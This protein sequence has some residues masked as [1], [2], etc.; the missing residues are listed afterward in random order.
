MK[1]NA[2]SK[3]RNGLI[4]AI[5]AQVLWGCFPLYV[6]LIKQIDQVDSEDFVAHRSIWSFG[7]LISVF[8]VS[9]YFSH[10]LLPQMSELSSSIRSPKVLGLSLLASILIAINWLAFVW[11][12]ANNQ[13][14]NASL[15]Y[16]I[17]PL[18]V[19][20][21][22]VLFLHEQLSVLKWIAVG[23]ATIGVSYMSFSAKGVPAVAL[24]IAV[25]FGLY[26]LVKNQTRVSALGGLTLETAILLIPAIAYLVYRIATS[27]SNLLAMPPWAYLVLL[28]SGP[29]TIAPL[30][31]YAAAVKHVPLSTVGF[32][33]CIGPTLQFFMGYFVLPEPLDLSRL[34]G[35]SIVWIGVGVFLVAMHQDRKSAMDS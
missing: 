12:V 5:L 10:P 19:V 2:N 20:L 35:F 4:C 28:G 14:L 6:S 29:A 17:C 32:F 24:I 7:F 22:G 21:L 1:S 8:L 25:S 31:L 13:I 30:A 9:R 15:G 23:L 33:Q 11:A 18:V 27:E 34:V 26:G 16:Y 3:F